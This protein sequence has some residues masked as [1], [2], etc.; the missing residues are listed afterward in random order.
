MDEQVEVVY[1][2]GVLRPLEQLPFAERQH[3]IITIRP[4]SISSGSDN[5]R[6]REM[7]W[8]RANGPLHAGQYVAIDGDTLVGVGVSVRDVMEQARARGVE[9]PLVHYVPSD[10]DL[11]SAGW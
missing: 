7:D 10:Q 11:P 9:L 8:I 5:S 1:E 3:L 2:G 4:K 6:S